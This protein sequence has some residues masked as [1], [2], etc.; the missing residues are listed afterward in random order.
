MS[1]GGNEKV[2]VEW[3]DVGCF[4]KSKGDKYCI[5]SV[6]GPDE[7][8]V[9]VDNNFYTNLMARENLKYALK[10]VKVMKEKAPAAWQAL[11]ERLAF[12]EEE[13][14]SW[15]RI[16]E[17]MYFPYDEEHDIYPLDDGFMMR[18]PWEE[19]RIL[20]EKRAWLY[21]NYHPLF[22]MRHRMS[23]QADSMLGMYLCSHLFTKEEI[24]RNYD[25]YQGVTLHHSSLSTCIFGIVACDIGYYDEAYHYFALFGLGRD[26]GTLF[27][28]CRY[29]GQN[30]F[31]ISRQ[32]IRI[33]HHDSPYLGK[34]WLYV[35]AVKRNYYSS[36]TNGEGKAAECK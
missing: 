11:A 33:K 27:T 16:A 5:C 28:A 8:N 1:Y 24:R 15:K 14:A 12:Q 23:K 3:A 29:C 32:D 13:A 4:V 36:T 17:N 31:K 34:V 18:K 10:A 25:F 20:A 21:E 7:Y 22:I 19:S 6:T 35:A 30:C 2:N 26:G 9:L